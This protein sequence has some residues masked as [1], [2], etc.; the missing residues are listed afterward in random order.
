MTA[1]PTTISFV[2]AA[3]TPATVNA[4]AVSAYLS[5]ARRFVLPLND[6]MHKGQAGRIGI[7]G[8]SFEYSGA[9]YFAAM[10]AL[11]VGMDLVHVFCAADAGPIIKSY[12]PELIVHPVLNRVDAVSL[13]EPWLMKLHGLVIGPGLGRD[14]EVLD[15]VATLIDLCRA[16]S[17]PVVID[18]DALFLIAQRPELVHDFDPGCVLTPN[19]VEMDRILGPDV[20]C[21]DAM[22]VGLRLSNLFGRSGRTTVLEKSAIDIVWTVKPKSGDSSG[23]SSKN[24]S[25][26]MTVSGKSA[27]ANATMH[28]PAHCL[29][30][31]T[32]RRCGGQGDVLSGALLAFYVWAFHSEALSQRSDQMAATACR[33]ASF[34]TRRCAEHA[35]AKR[36]RGMLT[37][38]MLEAVPIV[39]R[40]C[41]EVDAND[42]AASDADADMQCK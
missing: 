42:A 22:A 11:R 34:L 41:F 23:G 24:I 28:R 2:S 33:A 26:S 39:F 37:S 10:A 4:S 38:D 15:R 3:P 32:M 18:A 31:G 40:E 16:T 14:P 21:D 36:G 5:V 8:G 25:P 7:V 27:S 12:S 30:G 19:R 20:V 29:P 6:R 9:P 13:I 1:P 17:K 35:F